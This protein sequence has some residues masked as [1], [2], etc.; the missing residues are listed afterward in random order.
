MPE[1]PEVT[2]SPPSHMASDNPPHSPGNP[3]L[4]ARTTAGRKPNDPCLR[5]RS[6]FVLTFPLKAFPTRK[7]ATERLQSATP[8]ASRALDTSGGSSPTRNGSTCVSSSWNRRFGQSVERR[9]HGIEAMTGE[10]TPPIEQRANWSGPV[11]FGGVR[12]RDSQGQGRARNGL[13]CRTELAPL[14]ARQPRP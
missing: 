9:R 6:Y 1:A 10:T 12:R 7:F 13:V 3:R 5:P 8:S 2:P 4:K 14:E 11:S